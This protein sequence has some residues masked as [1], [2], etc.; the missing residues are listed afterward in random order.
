MF[1]IIYLVG[2]DSDLILFHS[3]ALDLCFTVTKVLCPKSLRRSQVY[4]KVRDGMSWTL[5][6]I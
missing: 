6:S 5:P 3:L 4:D 2:D 1:L